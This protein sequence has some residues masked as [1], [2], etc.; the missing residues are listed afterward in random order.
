MKEKKSKMEEAETIG[1]RIRSIRG[2]MTQ[3]EFANILKIRQAMISRYEADKE[4]PSSKV[5]LRIAKYHDS[6]MEWLLTG[7]SLFS[8]S[9]SKKKYISLDEKINLASNSLR[10][11]KIPE[12]EDFISMMKDLF[13]NRKR[14]QRV[15]EIYHFEK[16]RKKQQ[17]PRGKANV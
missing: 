6:S 15:L 13:D 9:G 12:A 7:K 5:L 1:D 10:D 2:S 3:E 8:E 14:M 4:V 16:S 17:S 11:T